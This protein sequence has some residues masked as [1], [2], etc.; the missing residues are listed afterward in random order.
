MANKAL[1]GGQPNLTANPLIRKVPSTLR[2]TEDFMK[3]FKAK[4]ISIGPLHHDDPTLHES[5]E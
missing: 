3:Y 4:V 2:R 1:D 5:K